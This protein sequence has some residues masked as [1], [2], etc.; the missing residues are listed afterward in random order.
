M[1]R[2]KARIGSRLVVG[3][4]ALAIFLSAIAVF[5]IRYGGP[6]YRKYALQDELVADILPPPAY[7]VE[8]C[9]EAS[10]LMLHPEQAEMHLQNLAGLE[11][12]YLAR[13]S[14]WQAANLPADQIRVLRQSQGHADEF[15]SALNGRFAPAARAGD[16]ETMR[17]VYDRELSPAYAR[18]HEAILQLVKM[19]TDF[20]AREHRFDDPMVMGALGL[21]GLMMTVVLGAI[22]FARR[23]IDRGIVAPLTMTAQ[24]MERMAHGDYSLEA[25]GRNRQDEIGTMAQAMEFFARPGWPRNRHRLSKDRLLTR[26]A[27]LCPSSRPRIWSIACRTHSPQNMK[28]CERITTIRWPR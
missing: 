21:V 27:A 6:I 22:L 3:A 14:Y 10:L 7:V 24:A 16:V 12:E 4:V 13:K 2:D 11:K 9:L 19:S 18:Q 26:S 25:E 23:F 28:A 15:W 1:I 5:Q 17:R 8:P 20:R